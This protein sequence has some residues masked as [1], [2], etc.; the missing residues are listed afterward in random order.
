MPDAASPMPGVQQALRKTECFGGASLSAHLWGTPFKLPQVLSVAL[1]FKD[2]KAP[3]KHVLLYSF[4][5]E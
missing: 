2:S 3:G 5:S 4:E 1:Y